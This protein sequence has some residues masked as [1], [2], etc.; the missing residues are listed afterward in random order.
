MDDGAGATGFE[1]TLRFAYLCWKPPL[2]NFEAIRPA[3]KGGLGPMRGTS[4][5]PGENRTSQG[6]CKPVAGVQNLVKPQGPGGLQCHK[7]ECHKHECHKLNATNMNATVMN[8]TVTRPQWSA[9]GHRTASAGVDPGG[10]YAFRQIE[11]H[12]LIHVTHR[13]EV[14]MREVGTKFVP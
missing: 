3:W 10:R 9:R 11:Q 8:A 12:H 14:E 2:N 13:G 4:P 7:H 1:L 6:E 5:S